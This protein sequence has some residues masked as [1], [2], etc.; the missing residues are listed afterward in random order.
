[1]SWLGGRRSQG[2]IFLAI[3]CV[4]GSSTVSSERRTAHE[5][6]W[7][8]RRIP[9][10]D[11]DGAPTSGL[12]RNLAMSG[13]PRPTTRV[14]LPTECRLMDMLL[15]HTTR[16]WRRND[17]GWASRIF[18]RLHATYRWVVI[19]GRVVHARRVFRNLAEMRGTGRDWRRMMRLS[20]LPQETV[21]NA[22]A[23]TGLSHEV[24]MRVSYG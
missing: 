14:C 6:T 18:G 13:Q 16:R 17:C 15:L 12:E 9:A 4:A 23:H 1:M 19:V 24:A 8:C 20:S 2:G 3:K 21:R 22:P 11:S 7:E 10:R 5:I